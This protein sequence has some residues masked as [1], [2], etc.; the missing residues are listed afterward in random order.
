[1]SDPSGI[2][3]YRV[4]LKVSYDN[5]ATWNTLQTWDPVTAT[6]VDA[7]AFTDCGGLYGWTVAARD[8]AG[9]LGA[10]GGAFFGIG[11]P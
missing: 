2:S 11:L 10:V 5:G 4:V 6:N 1:M 8:G 9:N 3:G 7:S